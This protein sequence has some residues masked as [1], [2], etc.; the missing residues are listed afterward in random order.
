M[1]LTTSLCAADLIDD[2]EDGDYSS[3]PTWAVV[4]VA[5]DAAVVSDPIRTDNLVLSGSGSDTDQHRLRTVIDHPRADF[6]LRL[7]FYGQAGPFDITVAL[8]GDDPGSDALLWRVT[9]N[10]GSVMS[11]FDYHGWSISS[12]L[13]AFPPGDGWWSMRLWSDSA[14]QALY[15]RINTGGPTINFSSSASVFGFAGAPPFSSLSVSFAGTPIQHVDN[16][17]LSTVPEPASV[18]LSVGL[19]ATVLRMR[20]FSTQP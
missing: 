19:L 17:Y 12:A 8:E 14:G 16:I 18:L 1:N 15:V 5:G 13:L 9:G 3:N 20:R 7:E 4:N 11:S 6:D 10:P 2:F